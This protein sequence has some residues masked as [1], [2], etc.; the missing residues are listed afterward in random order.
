MNTN[1]IT[2][3]TL[4][5]GSTSDSRNHILALKSVE[6][7]P[8]GWHLMCPRKRGLAPNLSSRR[9]ILENLDI[10]KHY[11]FCAQHLPPICDTRGLWCWFSP[12]PV[13]FL[14][15]SRV[16]LGL[17]NQNL[18]VLPYWRIPGNQH[19]INEFPI[20]PWHLF[21]QNIRFSCLLPI[22]LLPVLLSFDSFLFSSSKKDGASFRTCCL[23]ALF[24]LISWFL[25]RNG[26][27][28]ER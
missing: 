11:L 13:L 8:T 5:S 17:M 18:R 27:G 24:I 2:G 22:C 28:G 4:P 6:P 3:S 7:P 9:H 23:P 12:S 21:G 20:H 1:R 19:F 26:F 10:W 25:G 14:S 16:L 15:D